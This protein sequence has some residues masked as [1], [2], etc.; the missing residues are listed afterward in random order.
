LIDARDG[1]HLWADRFEGLLQ[2]VFDLQDE[3]TTKVVG[4][5]APRV[6]A[7]EIERA[8]RNRPD[9]LDAYDL[10]LRALAAVRE[11]T[12]E[13]S[14]EAFR[15]IGKALEIDPDYAVAAGLGA[16][17]CTLRVAQNWPV[18]REAE[19]ARGV[20]LGRLAVL[21][22]QQDAEALGSGGYAL[23]F[24]GGEFEEGLSAIERAIILN[25]NSAMALAHAGWV[26]TYLG[27][28]HEA[29]DALERSIRL[30]PRDPT[31]FRAYGALIPK[32]FIFDLRGPIGASR[33]M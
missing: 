16:W 11:M 25:P 21:K 18:D 17:A 5:I 8:K 32:A 7:A 2:D 33:W 14:D 4:A 3:M 24:L 28:A 23:A 31:L 10:Y 22:G 1:S 20:R 6:E 27:R 12:P 29:I 30:S 19:T 26:Q 9:S 15:L 13:S